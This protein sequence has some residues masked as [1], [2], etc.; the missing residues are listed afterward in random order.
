MECYNK[1]IITKNIDLKK[2]QGG[3]L[4]DCGKCQNCI[5]NKRTEKAIRFIHETETRKWKTYFLTFTYDDK[6]IYKNEKGYLS[7]NK[8]WVRK[9]RDKIYSTLYRRYIKS[10]KRKEY[11][12]QYKYMIK[13]EYG[14]NGTERPHYHVMLTIG[15]YASK[16]IH[17]F[18]KYFQGG[19][20]EIEEAESIKAVFYTAGYTAKKLE[21]KKGY[22][23][24][25]PEFLIMSRGLGKDWALENSEYLKEL[26]YIQIPTKN[27]ISKHKI[28][29]IYTEWLYRYGKWSLEDVDAYRENAQEKIKKQKKRLYEEIIEP[30]HK[31]ITGKKYNT[32]EDITINNTKYTFESATYGY[33]NTYYNYIDATGQLKNSILET[34]V[35]GRNRVLKSKAEKKALEYKI[36]KESKYV[37][38]I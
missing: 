23:N 32:E 29:R 27:G 25:E 30:I 3:I 34:W 33:H 37:K 12:K 20:Y 9:Q 24:I 36:R 22:D 38:Y 28:P 19:R 4:A 13:G 7:L 21:W 10:G 2:Y 31:R 17:L 8:N 18:I 1:I 16:I 15:K 35:L 26:K 11:H 5:M 6:N 14:E